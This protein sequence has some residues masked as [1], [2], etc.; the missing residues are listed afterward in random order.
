MGWFQSM[1]LRWLSRDQGPVPVVPQ[2][3]PSASPQPPSAPL[4][5]LE[6]D[7][8]SASDGIDEDQIPTPVTSAHPSDAAPTNPGSRS[9]PP[10]KHPPGRRRP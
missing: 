2:A 10:S 9:K 6:F 4:D 7:L 8:S 1:L 3:Q 5:P